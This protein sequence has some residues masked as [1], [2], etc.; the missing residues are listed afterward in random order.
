MAPCHVEALIASHKQSLEST[1]KRQV[2]GMKKEMLGRGLVRFHHEIMHAS[3]LSLGFDRS[4]VG[5]RTKELECAT[6]C[7]AEHCT[8]REVYQVA[9]LACC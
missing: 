9:D 6:T 4:R 7:F 2:D 8:Y 3:H 1:F 5:S